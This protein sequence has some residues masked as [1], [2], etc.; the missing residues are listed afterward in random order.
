MNF[1]L[2]AARS[3]VE[4]LGLCLLGQACLGLL[5]GQARQSNAVYQVFAVITRGPC[6]LM[7]RGVRGDPES[8]QVAWMTFAALFLL[9][10]GLAWLRKLL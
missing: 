3:I 4:M 1:L 2:S 8:A 9:W 6:R 7:A 10:I 5:I